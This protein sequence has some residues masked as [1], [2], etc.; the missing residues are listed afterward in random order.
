MVTHLL[1]GVG[2]ALASNGPQGVPMILRRTI[3]LVAALVSQGLSGV[4]AAPVDDFVSQLS[5]AGLKGLL[6]EKVRARWKQS[7]FGNTAT[8]WLSNHN[9]GDAGAIALAG[10]LEK[11]TVLTTLYIGGNNIGDA[12][13][14]ALAGALKKNTVLTWLRLSSNNIGNAGAAA[15]SGALEKN[16]V[17]TTLELQRNM[18]IG[19]AG[20]NTLNSIE[21]V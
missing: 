15:L 11:N 9:I 21:L 13:A 19:D 6:K 16:T 20:W 7:W 17:L 10:A 12:G 8:M 18:F 14:A 5:D 2:R 1:V 3:L 4:A